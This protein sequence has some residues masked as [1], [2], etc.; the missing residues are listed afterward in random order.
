[1]RLGLSS[2]NNIRKLHGI[3]NE[4]NRDVVAWEV[5]DACDWL[6]SIHNNVL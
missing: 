2:V 4:E 1:M 5:K 3:L 6:E